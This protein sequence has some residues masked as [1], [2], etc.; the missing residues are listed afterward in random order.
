[1][2]KYGYIY[3]LTAPNGKSYIGQVC[4]YLTNGD[5]K[6]VEN[7]WRQHCN[8][9]HGKNPDKGCVYLNRAI[10]KY[11]KDNFTI[12][13][14]CRYPLDRLD[15][16]E[17]LLIESYNTLAPNGYNLQTGGTHTKHSKITCK[18]RS[19]SLKKL[20]Q[21]STKRAIWSKAKKGK[22]QKKRRKRSNSRDSHLP[23]YLLHY[24]SGKYEGYEISCHPKCKSKKFTKS[25]IPMEERLTQAK[26]FLQQLNL[27]L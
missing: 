23:K 1:M 14:I 16:L 15:F 22:Q 8:S 26:A 19:E 4:E 7:R 12:E 20:L 24:K 11:G 25:K 27:Q 3:K 18:K 2:K 10:R 21:D 13:T 9:A 5:I 6:G 17:E